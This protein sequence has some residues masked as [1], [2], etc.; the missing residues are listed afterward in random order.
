M[1]TPTPK[2][3]LTPSPTGAQTQAQAQDR[4]SGFATA[5]LL[6]KQAEESAQDIQQRAFASVLPPEPIQEQSKASP[7]CA[8]VAEVE[9]EAEV[10]T[11]Q[12][13]APSVEPANLKPTKEDGTSPMLR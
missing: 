11:E 3:T 6:Q 8:P 13:A 7:I 2:P 4:K 1:L 10:E 5:E 9:V 12:R